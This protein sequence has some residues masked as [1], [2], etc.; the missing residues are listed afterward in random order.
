MII[1][2][3]KTSDEK[4]WV[5]CKALSYLFSPF[6]DDRETEKPAL[7]TD[8]YDKRIELVA[9]SDGQI[10]GLIDIDIYSQ[11]N[12]Q[13]YLYA[14]SQRTAYLTNFAVHPDYQGQGIAQALYEKAE[15]AL[16]DAGVEKLAIFTRDG[17]IANHL[18]QKWGGQLICSDYLVIGAPKDTPYVRFGVDLPNAKL[19]FTDETGQPAPYYLREGV[20]VVTDQAD[21]ELFDI[22]DVYQELTYVVDLV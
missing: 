11:E 21:L 22:E 7:L 19:A 15:Q 13:T 10:V 6:F 2:D 14:P 20:Y 9:E 16:K 18:Y 3:Y 8:I 5:Y 4:G 1:R 12:S 17:D